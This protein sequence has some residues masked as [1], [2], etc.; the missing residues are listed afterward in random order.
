MGNNTP[1]PNIT[2]KIHQLTRLLIAAGKT[3][4]QRPPLPALGPE[5]SMHL[6]MGLDRVDYQRVA[7]TG[8]QLDLGPKP[9][10]LFA[11]VTFQRIQPALANRQAALRSAGQEPLQ[12]IKVC[13][14]MLCQKPGMNTQ[15]KPDTPLRG[16][17]GLNALPVCPAHTGNHQRSDA[18]GRGFCQHLLP[19]PVKSGEVEMAMGVHQSHGY[20]QARE[21]FG[22]CSRVLWNWISGYRSWARFRFTMV[23][24]I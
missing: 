2:T 13:L 10:K 18:A 22:Q 6:V 21:Q 9:G 23:G 19:N 16:R 8:R 17:Q 11:Q 7:E 1:H 12:L 3:V 20:L 15:T 24:A 4:H 5:G 14:T